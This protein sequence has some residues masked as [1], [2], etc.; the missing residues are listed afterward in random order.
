[1]LTLQFLILLLLVTKLG[2]FRLKTETKQFTNECMKDNLLCIQIVLWALDL[3]KTRTKLISRSNQ[4][5]MWYVVAK[6]FS[7]SDMHVWLTGL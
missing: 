6:L 2:H 4:R 5:N 7:T 1:V 3:Q